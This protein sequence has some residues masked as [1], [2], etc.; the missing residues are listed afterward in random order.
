MTPK[1]DMKQVIRDAIEEQ[2]PGG[3]CGRSSSSQVALADKFKWVGTA[4]Q[5][6]MQPAVYLLIAAVFLVLLRLIGS[7][8]DFR[9]SLSVTVHGMMPFVD[10]DAARRF[11]VVLS[12]T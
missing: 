5:V 7:E 4:S 9:R 11:P 1:L 3:H 12:R 8:I 10:R 6:V 2:R